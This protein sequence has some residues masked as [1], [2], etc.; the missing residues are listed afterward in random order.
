MRERTFVVNSISKTGNSTGWRIGWV[1]SPEE[2][3][4]KLRGIHDT[5]VM[6]APTPLQK[7]AVELLKMPDEFYSILP[8]K[9]KSCCTKKPPSSN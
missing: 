3:T 1:I 2:Y 4:S 9:Y 7:G 8:S 5:M 6:Q